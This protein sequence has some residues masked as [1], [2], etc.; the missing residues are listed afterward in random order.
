MVAAF[1]G[2]CLLAGLVGGIY[3]ALY[4]S[5]F[6]PIEVLRGT[7]KHRSGT[8]KLRQG[9]VVFQFTWS[10]MLIIGTLT[11]YDQLAYIQTKNLGLVRENLLHMTMEGDTKEK[12]D[13]I[14]TELL[15]HPEFLTVSRS[16]QNPLKVGNSTW[17]PTWRGKDPE[18]K[19]TI[20]II[21]ADFDYPETMKMNIISGRS[22]DP[23]RDV[24]ASDNMSFLVNQEMAR[25]MGMD[26]PVGEEIKFWGNTATVVGLLENFHISSMRQPIG[27]L[28]IRLDPE[29]LWR[30]DAR[31]APGKEERAIEILSDLHDRFS[32][33]NPFTYRF[34]SEDFDRMYRNEAALGKLATAFATLA[35]LISVLGLFGLASFTAIQRTKEIGIRKTLGATVPGLIGLMSKDFVKLVVISFVIAVPLADYALDQWLNEFKYRIDPSWRLFAG[36]GLFALGIA[37]ATVST[38]A[39]RVVRANPTDSLRSE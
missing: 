12:F 6:H 25:T 29:K 18:S 13:A 16:N 17:G 36:A 2:I 1:V 22:F 38:Q 4:L 21:K 24:T 31:I 33:D 11:V 32:P 27:P 35:G 14:K 34:V 9:L 7:Y 28:I 10:I 39:I 15:T 26:D 20:N 8:G 5:G 19:Y 3:P 23:N 37:W 30:L